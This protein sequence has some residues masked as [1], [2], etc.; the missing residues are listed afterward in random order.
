MEDGLERI[1]NHKLTFN[2]VFHTY[3]PIVVTWGMTPDQFWNGEMYLAAVYREAHELKL[4]E[5]NFDHW[6]QGVYTYVAIAKNAPVLNALS[7]AT[8]PDEYL[9]KPIDIYTTEQERKQ[10]EKHIE[11]VKEKQS[12]DMAMAY[13]LGFSKQS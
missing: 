2:E 8:R 13:L 6:L 5:R 7:K 10:A 12:H 1:S 9:E 3:L 4:K 11:D